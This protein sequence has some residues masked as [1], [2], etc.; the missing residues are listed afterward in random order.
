MKKIDED[1][2]GALFGRRWRSWLDDAVQKT[3]RSLTGADIIAGDRE[4]VSGNEE[5]KSRAANDPSSTRAASVDPQFNGGSITLENQKEEYEIDPITMRK[6]PTAT[7]RL[8]SQTSK[9]VLQKPEKGR[10]PIQTVTSRPEAVKEGSNTVQKKGQGYD[11]PVKPWQSLMREQQTHPASALKTQGSNTSTDSRMQGTSSWLAQEGFTRRNNEVSKTAAVTNAKGPGAMPT[12][13]K[14]ESALDRHHRAIATPSDKPH[15]VSLSCDCEEETT[16]DVDLLR[17]SDVRASAGLRGKPANESLAENQER[18]QRLEQDFNN[19]SVDTERALTQELASEERMTKTGPQ[20]KLEISASS[21]WLNEIAENAPLVPAADTSTPQAVRK[22]PETKARPAKDNAARLTAQIVPLKIRLD[23]MKADY[24]ELRQRWIAQKRRQKTQK[25]HEEEVNA[26][27][28]AMQAMATRSSD[29]IFK[30][31]AARIEGKDC[32]S[33]PVSRTLQSFYPGE[34]DMA[35]NVHEFARSDR[36][37][38]KRAPHADDETNSKLEKLS[39]DRALIR[40]IRGIY[41]EAYGLIDTAHRQ[42]TFAEETKEA[43]GAPQESS[44]SLFEATAHDEIVS[45]PESDSSKSLL[46]DGYT[47][48]P[49]PT[50]TSHEPSNKGVPFVY[51]ILAYDSATKKV[52]SAKVTSLAPFSKEQPLM[53][54][55]ALEVLKNPGK[56]LPHLVTLHNKGYTVVSGTSNTLVFKREA[57]GDELATTKRAEAIRYPNP[58]DGTIAQ[59]GNF[60]SPT[61]FVN[62]DSPIPLQELE[63]REQK[64]QEA[65]TEQK[66]A[67]FKVRKEEAVFSGPK[68]GRWQDSLDRRHHRHQRKYGRRK[69]RMLARMLWTGAVTAGCCYMVGLVSEMMR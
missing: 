65:E 29:P 20:P 50:S 19:R 30:P 31:E 63:A 22:H 6:V 66:T 67:S 12:T 23:A 48:M 45:E 17:P 21:A 40:E 69:R 44:T 9:T 27:K 53:P 13:A 60:A 33:R 49:L 7:S 5:P 10:M 14:I 28:E 51:R 47:S 34:G 37:Y 64:R 16:D 3:A 39:R 55:E 36:W 58:I 32:V 26:Q 11:I 35:S 56:F 42:P 43:Q 59:T 25:I 38:K 68:R 8:K 15:G 18:H 41:E 61:G 24:A 4:N 52:T 2:Y 46:G 1:P 62:H 54:V 57:K